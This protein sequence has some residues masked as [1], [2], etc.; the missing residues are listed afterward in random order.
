MSLEA[1]R[2][3]IL[4]LIDNGLISAEEGI[5]LLNALNGQEDGEAASRNVDPPA[6]Q[7]DLPAAEEPQASLPEPE[8]TASSR[9]EI[10]GP[11][12]EP[13][14]ARADQ[15]QT[16]DEPAAEVITPAPKFDPA[17]VKWRSWWWIPM[18]VGVG[19]TLIAALLMYWAYSASGVGF[20]FACTWFPF[21]LG[22]GVMALA[23]AS[24]TM[25]WI[26]VRVHQKPG[27]KPQRIAISLPIPLHLTAWFLRTF[28][29]NI[30]H[31]G[32]TGLD[33]LIMALDATSPDT[34]F[35]VEVNEGNNGERV[36][37]YIG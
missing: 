37:V 4:E 9:V 21:M 30:P 16:A 26:H 31:M 34:P 3:K 5:R 22:V 10:P 36:E 28:G 8:F 19:I 6:L 20:W 7:I 15:H 11:E 2:I 32:N 17:K 13:P 12:F 1:E 29:K 24:R 35:Y 27:E 25:R 23:W 18:W 14:P 33:E